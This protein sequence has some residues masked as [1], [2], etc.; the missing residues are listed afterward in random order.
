MFFLLIGN[1]SFSKII[2]PLLCSSL[3]CPICQKL[4][5]I[6]V[7]YSDNGYKLFQKL[8]EIAHGNAD[9]ETALREYEPLRRLV[10]GIMD[11]VKKIEEELKSNAEIKKALNA[12]GF[13]NGGE[14]E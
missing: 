5:D 4:Y 10:V 2:L 13:S 9:E 11:N 14:E 6:P 7:I 12:I 1:E 8:S 3:T